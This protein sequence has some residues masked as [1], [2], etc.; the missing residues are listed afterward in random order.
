[1]EM[2]VQISWIIAEDYKDEFTMYKL[3][4][5]NTVE[6]EDNHVLK[7]GSLTGWQP[8]ATGNIPSLTIAVNMHMHIA[9][10]NTCL[11][12]PLTIIKTS[13]P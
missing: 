5:F 8:P 13:T 12:K 2:P 11:I 6:I 7:I 9:E 1:M 10:K 3:F 4:L